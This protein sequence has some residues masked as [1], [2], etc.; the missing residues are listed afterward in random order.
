MTHPIIIIGA[1]LA[2]RT[3]AREFRKLD[4]TTLA[5]KMAVAQNDTL[6]AQTQVV[7]SNPQAQ[8]V[9]TSQGEFHYSQL[10][11]ATGAQAIRIP[12]VDFSVFHDRL[13]SRGTK[14]P[15]LHR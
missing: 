1:G 6:L 8:T 11:L 9:S 2:G 4:A 15:P 13:T 3:T 10:V 5:A 7:A 14:A 12:L